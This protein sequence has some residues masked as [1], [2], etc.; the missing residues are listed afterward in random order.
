MVVLAA[1]AQEIPTL[2]SE[3]LSEHELQPLEKAHGSP[4]W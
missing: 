1:V 2:Q 3:E 4:A